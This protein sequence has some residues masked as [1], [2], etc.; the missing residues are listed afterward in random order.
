[1]K[2]QQSSTNKKHGSDG[3][4]QLNVQL[5][6]TGPRE[7]SK[8]CIIDINQ[9]PNDISRLDDK[10]QNVFKDIRKHSTVQES[11]NDSSKNEKPYPP[12]KL[13]LKDILAKKPQLATKSLVTFEK[14]PKTEKSENNPM[15]AKRPI[16]YVVSDRI[17]ALSRPRIRNGDH[18]TGLNKPRTKMAARGF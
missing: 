7:K 1:M 3:D 15:T 9:K 6:R 16:E 12:S 8:G 4:R 10:K 2:T 13:N 17:L 18:N 14:V 5:K 11:V